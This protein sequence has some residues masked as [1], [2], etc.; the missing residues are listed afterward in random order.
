[1]RERKDVYKFTVTR[2]KYRPGLRYA[3]FS[4]PSYE[5]AR[6]YIERLKREVPKVWLN[7]RIKMSDNEYVVTA[8]YVGSPWEVE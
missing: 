1:M 5:E 7:P 8:L 4:T 6:Q 2:E 3:V